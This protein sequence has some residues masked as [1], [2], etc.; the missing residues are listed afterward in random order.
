M[1]DS[2]LSTSP[3][4]RIDGRALAELPSDLYIPPDALEVFLETLRDL[5]ICCF[6]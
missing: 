1:D 3:P 4:A 6:I 5:W 2:T